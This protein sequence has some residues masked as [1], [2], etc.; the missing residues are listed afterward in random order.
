MT[1]ETFNAS[2]AAKPAKRPSPFSIRLSEDERA[3]L[4]AAAGAQPLGGFIRDRL[5]GEAVT[6]RRKRRAPV[7]DHEALGRVLG[8]LGS[9]RLSAN[10]N[11][12]AKA[13]HTGALPLD[14]ETAT[15]LR[16]ACTEVREMRDTLMTALGLREGPS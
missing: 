13:A 3:A 9:S 14:H 15:E 16:R 6:P 1:L 7:A 11:Q 12:L 8:A 10:L 5:M 2:A 4:K